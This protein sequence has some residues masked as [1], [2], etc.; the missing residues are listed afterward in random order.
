MAV[1]WFGSYRTDRD[2]VWVYVKSSVI[3]KVWCFT[4]I[5]IID[6]RYAPT[7]YRY[8]LNKIEDCVKDIKDWMSS[9]FLLIR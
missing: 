4:R 7:G 6:I 8:Q 2:H 5:S 9:N 3:T 1:S